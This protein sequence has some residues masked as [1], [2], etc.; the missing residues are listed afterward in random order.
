MSDATP[1]QPVD[2]VVGTTQD[3]RTMAVLA[4]VLQLVGGWIAPLVIFF[5]RRQSRF[6]TFHALQVLLFQGVCLFLTMFVMAGVFIA[7]ALGIFAGGWTLPHGASDAPPLF[8]LLFGIFWLGF[9]VFWAVKLLLVI[10]YG[11]KA[12][13]GE[14]AEYPILGRFARHILS[15]GPGGAVINP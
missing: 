1:R 8:L 11:V 2:S 5:L 3:E 4:H 13:R 6:V 14:W 7:V 10:I 9:A 12:G 15:I